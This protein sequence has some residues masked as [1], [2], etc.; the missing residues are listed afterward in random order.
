MLVMLGDGD[1]HRSRDHLML[2]TA[3]AGDR[4]CSREHLMLVIAGSL[5]ALVMVRRSDAMTATSA[6]ITIRE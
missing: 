5:L 1:L 3:G 6:S 4:H 2:A